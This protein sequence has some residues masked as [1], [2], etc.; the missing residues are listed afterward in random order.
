MKISIDGTNKTITAVDFSAEN[1]LNGVAARI[2]EKL[3]TA[4]VTWD[5]VNSRFIITS[6][7]T[8]EAS[9]VGMARPIRP[10]RTSRQ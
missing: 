4:N 2:A 3:T 10:E 9:A 5:A 8:G 1:N 7:S 6:K